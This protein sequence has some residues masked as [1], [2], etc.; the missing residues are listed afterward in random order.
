MEKTDIIRE[1]E[2]L[3]K[4]EKDHYWRWQFL[5]CFIKEDLEKLY[6]LKTKRKL[7]KKSNRKIVERIFLEAKD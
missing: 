1:F 4:E 7:A 5:G 3:S 6:I 2:R